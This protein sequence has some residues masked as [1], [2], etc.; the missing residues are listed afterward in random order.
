MHRR[1]LD[2]MVEKTAAIMFMF[3]SKTRILETTAP[4]IIIT[5][6]SRHSLSSIEISES[7]VSKIS[8]LL[9]LFDFD[10]CSENITCI[11]FLLIF[12]VN[13]TP[14]KSDLSHTRHN[15]DWKFRTEP[16]CIE[17]EFN[18]NYAQ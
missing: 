4:E 8:I 17:V 7:A 3:G 1:R 18:W 2:T 5:S 14:R 6:C 16:Y 10:Y 12:E 11:A 15:R 13:L 9:C